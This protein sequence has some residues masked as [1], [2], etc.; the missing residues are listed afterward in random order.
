[1]KAGDVAAM[2]ADIRHQGYSTKRSMLYVWENVTPGLPQRYES[3]E[4]SPIRSTSNGRPSHESLRLRPA[5]LRREPRASEERRR[6]SCPS[7]CSKQHFKPE[8]AVRTYAE[9]LDGLGGDGPAR[10]RRRRLQRAPQ[11]ALRPDELAQPDGR[12][13]GAA[14]QAAQAADLRQPAAAARAAA[15][16]RGAGDARLP[17][18]RPHHL[19]LRPRHPARVQGLQRAARPS[20]APASRRRGRSSRRAWTEEVFSYEGK[21]WSYKDVAIWPRPV[22]QPHPPVWVPVVGSKEIDRV[23]RP[24][25]HPDHARAWRGA[26]PARG[27]HPLLRASAW[28]QPATASRPTTCHRRQRLRRR[29][30]G[31][32]GEGGRRP[33]R[34]ISI[35]RCSATATSPRR[36]RSAKAGY[37]SQPRPTTC[38]RRT[39][40]R[41]R[42][43]ARA[44]AT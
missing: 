4:L 12:V 41:R 8:V 10:L 29:Q 6:P 39:S 43:C 24:P 2:P 13:G 19:G 16:G 1:M 36:R 11:L 32:G 31:A 26:R 5:R 17:V 42:C 27:H 33:T 3:G 35:A 37:V 9:H 44:S 40:A 18:Q 14:H 20:R 22:Q 21:F 38:G 34:S 15:P 7:R 28:P 30:Q 25:Q 23:G